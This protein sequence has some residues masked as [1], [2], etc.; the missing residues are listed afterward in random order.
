MLI[1]LLFAAPGWVLQASLPLLQSHRAR[2]AV[3]KPGQPRRRRGAIWLILVV[4]LAACTAPADPAPP[5]V[6]ATTTITLAG[7]GDGITILQEVLAPFQREHPQLRLEFLV[8]SGGSQALQGAQAGEFDLAVLLSEN[9]SAVRLPGLSTFALAEDPLA[10]VRHPELALSQL[11]TAHLAAIYAGRITNWRAVGGPDFPIIVLTRNDDDSATRLLRT[12]LFGAA[13][14][15]PGTIVLTR[16]TDL[17]EAVQRTPGS[18][19]FGSYGD[20]VISGLTAQTL[21][22]D[23]V[24]PGA[25]LGGYPLPSR[26]L[27]LA[28]PSNSRAGL[29]PLLTYLQSEAALSGLVQVGLTPI[30]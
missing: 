17:R 16:D 7:S 1:R 8:S 11:S 27:A 25:T 23:G 2:S 18:I 15:S 21:A 22:L 20:F 6:V 3:R 30:N 4:L 29:E 13:A 10:F 26:T 14:W 24:Q 12:T 19:G 9:L 28:F 5:A